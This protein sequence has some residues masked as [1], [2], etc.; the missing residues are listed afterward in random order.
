[1]AQEDNLI[2]ETIW[3][4]LK[5]FFV[6]IILFYV[7]SVVTKGYTDF[8]PAAAERLGG[9]FATVIFPMLIG[10]WIARY[11]SERFEKIHFWCPHC[12]MQ[13]LHTHE[14]N[15]IRCER[16]NGTRVSPIFIWAYRVLV[17]LV[18]IL[19]ALI[20]FGLGH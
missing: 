13:T 12:N 19:I 18:F 7:G 8:S 5:I 4:M 9:I 15:I 16:C 1:V 2:C 10:I 6:L 17:V 11:L 20:I 14:I 3:F